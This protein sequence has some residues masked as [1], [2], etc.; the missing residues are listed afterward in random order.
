MSKSKDLL[1]DIGVTLVVFT[2]AV[3]L[4]GFTNYQNNKSDQG[5]TFR[6]LETGIALYEQT[7]DSSLFLI[8][9]AEDAN[10]VFPEF[11]E[12]VNW[13][14]EV[15]LGYIEYP[16]PTTGYTLKV[17]SVT[18]QGP[19]ITVNY[20]LLLPSDASLNLTVVTQPTLFVALN[21]TDLASSSQLTIRFRNELTNQTTSL[22]VSPDEIV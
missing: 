11:N 1:I 9:S 22:S 15:V 20:Q 18:R 14:Q 6:Q 3:L 13:A 12:R 17:T 21:R 8:Q 7:V 16:Q 4:L 2:V 19:Q 10:L 5:V